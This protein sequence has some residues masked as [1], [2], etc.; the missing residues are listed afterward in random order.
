MLSNLQYLCQIMVMSGITKIAF[1]GFEP[2]IK[3]VVEKITA[4]YMQHIEII[5][6][7]NDPDIVINARDLP[8]APIKMGVLLDKI[9]GE[10][11][12][13]YKDHALSFKKY[14]LIYNDNILDID[15]QKYDLSERE[16]DLIAEL[17]LAGESG[18]SRDHLLTKIWGYRA[19]LD[20]H[21]LET[22][23]YRLRQKIERHSD[24]PQ[25]IVTFDG[26]YRLC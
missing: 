19:D 2:E 26:G 12:Y 17:I 8:Q 18:C 21:A 6:E 4:D 1:Q 24:N 3:A 5:D 16:R 9:E 10:I 25:Y 11:F 23:I 7:K 20:T 14:T 13:K 15:G 22:Q